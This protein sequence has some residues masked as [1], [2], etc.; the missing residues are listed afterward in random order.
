MSCSLTSQ[1]FESFNVLR[2]EGLTR[3]KF[4]ARPGLRQS[5]PFKL[6]VNIPSFKV[7]LDLESNK[8]CGYNYC[9]LIKQ[10]S[11]KPSK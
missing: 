6:H 11:E 7:I 8:C 9:F 1:I 4:L 5:V 3:S 10:K 2:S